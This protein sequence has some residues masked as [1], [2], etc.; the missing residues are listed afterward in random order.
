[1]DLPNRLL[2]HILRRN[3]Q[4]DIAVVLS[5]SLSDRQ[6]GKQVPPSAPAREHNSAVGRNRYVHIETGAGVTFLRQFGQGQE[7]IATVI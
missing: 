7:R 6:S 3:N 4:S 5:Q 2:I 1:V